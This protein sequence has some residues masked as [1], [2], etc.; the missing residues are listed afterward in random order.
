V[1]FV[2]VFCGN[3]LF[4]YVVCVALFIVFSYTLLSFMHITYFYLMHVN[5]RNVPVL[6]SVFL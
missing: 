2:G 4:T 6:R 1:L 5:Q 3:N